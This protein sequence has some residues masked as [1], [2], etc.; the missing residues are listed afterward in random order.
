MDP[1]DWAVRADIEGV[2]ALRRQLGAAD[3]G[4]LPGACRAVRGP[5]LP[6]RWQGVSTPRRLEWLMQVCQPPAG[7]VPFVRYQLQVR[8]TFAAATAA[9]MISGHPLCI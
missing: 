3:N 7:V 5:L 1:A 2:A 9:A 8:E 4:R 6:H